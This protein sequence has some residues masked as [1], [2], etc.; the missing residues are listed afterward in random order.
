LIFNDI[1]KYYN[2]ISFYNYYFGKDNNYSEVIYK[3]IEIGRKK[4][5]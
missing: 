3:I 5:I 2:D 4:E 1:N